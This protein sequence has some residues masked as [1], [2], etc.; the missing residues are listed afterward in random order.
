MQAESVRIHHRPAR[1]RSTTATHTCRLPDCTSC[2]L[3]SGK[4]E[5]LLVPRRPQEDFPPASP[6]SF[7]GYRFPP[8]PVMI[9]TPMRLL[10]RLAFALLAFVLLS[11][12]CRASAYDSRP[13]LV[14]IIVLDGQRADALQQQR[15]AFAENGFRLFLDGGAWFADARYDHALTWTSAGHGTLLTGAPPAAH[16]LGS[17]H[18]WDA[19]RRRMVDS[20][21]D[22]ATQ[23]V[24]LPQGQRARGASPRNLLASTLGD[25]LKLATG[26]ASRVF[27]V[28]LK[29]TA[30]A[31]SGGHSADAA[32]W[33]ERS[34]GAFVSSTYYMPD[35]PDWAKAFNHS[36][37]NEKLWDLEW[38]D[39]TGA[40]LRTT[41][42][43]DRA[44]KETKF[45]YIVGSTPFANQYTLDFARE[46]IV[47]EKLGSGPATD[48]LIVSLSANDI[49]LHKVGPDAP[50]AAAMVRAT[51]R[52][53]AE[54]LAFLGRRL[55]LANLWIALSADHGFEYSPKYAQRFR[56]QGATMAQHHRVREQMNAALAQSFSAGKQEYVVGFE[57]KI[58]FLSPQAFAAAGILDEA[59]AER[60]VG[61][62]ILKLPTF[63][64]YYTRAQLAAGHLPRD[65]IS[66]LYANSYFPYGG[67]YVVAVPAP[68]QAAEADIPVQHGSPYAYNTRVPLALYGLPFR[69]G[70]YTQRSQPADLAV[71]LSTLLGITPPSHATGRVLDEALAAPPSPAAAESSSAHE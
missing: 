39:E 26:G 65:P 49:L 60:R 58:A 66:R 45:Y 38:K 29:D 28:S 24:G 33:I 50:E 40:V 54:F 12:Y 22:D 7:S 11:V 68:F 27:A 13:R 6:V 18:W 71:T 53:L 23:L 3:Y 61:E 35:L 8:Q 56:L 4:T 37:R 52:Q 15:G 20:V 46:L 64:G 44:D 1:R 57:D 59:E 70:T 43:Q 36:R 10:P 55:G 19:S 47:N 25:E 41:Q 14:V 9:P 21:E 32:Y 34:G 31:I 63:R 48:L 42:R 2:L 30:A 69:P 51:D 67:W 16:G 5:M 62:V 17:N